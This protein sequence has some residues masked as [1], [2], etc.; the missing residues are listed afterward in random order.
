MGVHTFRAPT[1]PAALARV[2]REIGEDAIIL[3]TRDVSQSPPIVEV[4][5]RSGDPV[6]EIEA[7]PAASALSASVR[8]RTRA[9]TRAGDEHVGEPT[10]ATAVLDAVAG[11]SSAVH[12]RADLLDELAQLRTRLDRMNGW[13]LA[14]APAEF[15]VAAKRLH[16]RLVE[17]GLDPRL[18]A[19]VI[20]RSRECGDDL[21]RHAWDQLAATVPIR[22]QPPAGSHRVVTLVGPNGVGKTTTCA[23]L[24]ARAVLTEKRS[25]ALVTTDDRRVGAAAP[26]SFYADV[27]D[28]PFACVHDVGELRRALRALSDVDFVI[29][30]T[31]GR[32]ARETHEISALEPWLN[33][34]PQVEP[35]LVLSAST[36]TATNL[37]TLRAFA[38]IEPE[39]VLITKIDEA[40]RPGE[41]ANVLIRGHL[42]LSH[43]ACGP[44][45][46]DDLE[47]AT[48][49]TV[50]RM[51]LD[52]AGA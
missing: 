34:A 13:L 28:V 38:A 51:L 48:R 32:M 17:T 39:A 12:P 9:D 35:W 37:G 18:A 11:P 44:H 1:I 31:A 50:P 3:E 20:R 33:A 19:A 49:A 21:A 45:V 7:A 40:T 43:V 41:V 29:V 4:V 15:D 24:A 14:D 16:V 47:V 23:K 2:R 5:A 10:L 30:D 26:L 8:E 6:P 25:V 36:D 42:P 22:A 27:L 46:P 52:P